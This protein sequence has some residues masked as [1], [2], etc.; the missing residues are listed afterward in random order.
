MRYRFAALLLFSVLP[1]TNALAAPV[2][3]PSAILAL[4]PPPDPRETV[5]HFRNN[6]R[7]GQTGVIMLARVLSDPEV[8]KLPSIDRMEDPRAWLAE[9]Q[10]V[11]E[12]KGG[13][14]LR[15]TF[16]ASTRAEQVIILN[17][18]LRANLSTHEGTI[19]YGEKCLRDYEEMIPR[20]EKRIKSAQNP[21][22]AASLQESLHELRTKQ[23]PEFR[24]A[25]ARRKQ[26]NVI[27]WAE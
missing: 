4:G 8:K 23:I 5:E 12:E 22:K 17:A 26:F 18:I 14:Y 21:Q 16:R 15:F 25:I 3:D 7:E 6:Q 9:N 19:K 13:R 1:V 20:L 10:R 27:R 11:T 24:A 2:P